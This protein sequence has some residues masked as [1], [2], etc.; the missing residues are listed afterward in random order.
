MLELLREAAY[1]ISLLELVGVVLNII[2]LILL[3]KRSVYC[4]PFGIV[5][6][7]ISIFSFI[8]VGLYAEAFLYAFYVFVGV[9]GWI[10]WVQNADDKDQ[11]IP[12]RWTL[13]QHAIT[14]ILGTLATFGLGV[15]LSEY[16]DAERPFEDSFSTSF[17]IIAT[18][19][20]A[21]QV[22]SGWFYWIALNGF[23]V[24]LY[25]DRGLFLYAA[26]AGVYTVMSVVGYKSWRDAKSKSQSVALDS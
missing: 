20:E 4:W 26:L 18:F 6:S 7:G 10:K 12:V 25:A 24:W 11:I 14:I 8:S 15:Y 16:T 1:S 17:S 19:L 5:G 23:S 22:L 2:F 9:Y 21:K 13:R 3:I